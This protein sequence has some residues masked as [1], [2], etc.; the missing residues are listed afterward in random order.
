MSLLIE[1]TVNTLRQVRERKPLVHNITNYVVMNSS[2]N[3]LLSQGASP[4]M[5]HSID[6]VAD[7]VALAG[8][9]VLN[10]GTLERDWIASMIAAGKAAN[11]RPIPVLLDP[12]G[13]G[14]TPYRTATTRRLLEEVQVTVLRGNASEVLSMQSAEAQ[15]KGVDSLHSV[16]DVKDAAVELA[17]DLGL[18]VG[19]SGEVD[20]ITDGQRTFRVAN[21]HP[22]M[23]LVT[24]LGCGLTATVGA[25]CAVAEDPLAATTGAFAFYGLAGEIAARTA[26]APGSFQIAFLDALYTI[27]EEELRAGLKIAEG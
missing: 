6:E 24:G 11:A 17:R 15:T 3:V 12:V 23:P 14:A 20:L 9:L 18:I 16:E 27:D 10:I 13:S 26:R 2:A 4:V 7:M 25:F 8:A 19:I 1:E 5:A 21:G 22:L